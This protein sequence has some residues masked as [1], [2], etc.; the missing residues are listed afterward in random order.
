MELLYSESLTK[1]TKKVDYGGCSDEEGEESFENWN[2]K[3]GPGEH[4]ENAQGWYDLAKAQ[5]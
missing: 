2:E 1:S 3:E 5:L 4:Q